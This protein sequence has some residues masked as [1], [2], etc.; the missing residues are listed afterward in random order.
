MRKIISFVVI[1]LSLFLLHSCFKANDNVRHDGRC[2]GSAYCSACT[3][4]SRCGHCGSGGTC[5]VCSGSSSERSYS[6]GN[7]SRKKNK[8]SSSGTYKSKHNSSLE[9]YLP[10]RK[11]TPIYHYETNASL[12]EDNFLYTV[13]KSV[14]IRTGPGKNYPIVETVTKNTKLIFLYEKA[15]WYKVKVVDSKKEGY[16]YKEGV[17]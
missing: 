9:L 15:N 13:Y 10:A 6:S 8:H 4:C 12:A 3:N 11:K 16:V 14:N 2:T 5:G 7:S 17:K 1:T